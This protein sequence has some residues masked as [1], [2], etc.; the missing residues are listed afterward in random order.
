MVTVRTAKV[1]DIKG[2]LLCGAKIW[3]SL[4]DV[5]PSRWIEDEIE[6]LHQ[7]SAEDT[8]R[9]V[10]EDP[11]RITLAAEED[12]EIVGFAMGRTDKSGLSWLGFM[13]VS[14]THRRGGI[15]RELIQRYI[16]ESRVRGAHKVSL[17]TAPE[18][19]SAVKLYVDMGFVPEGLMRRHRYGVDL[20]LFSK[21]LT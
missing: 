5:L 15:G 12:G 10:I 1:G 9:R 21:F 14:P 20:I 2:L 7:P 4:R 16:Y 11:T 3:E 13:G 8:L 17:N 18:L 19:K 6:R